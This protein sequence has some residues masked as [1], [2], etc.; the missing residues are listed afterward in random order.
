MIGAEFNAIVQETWPA[1][2]SK[3][4]QVRDW[5]SA[6]TSDITDQLKTVPKRLPTGP[7]RKPDLETT[8]PPQSPQAAAP[9][10]PLDSER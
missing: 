6:Q 3:I 8:E 5:V 9:D 1:N 7:I 2:P 10:R 4:D